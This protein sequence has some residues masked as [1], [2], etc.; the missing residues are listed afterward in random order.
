MSI[1]THIGPVRTGLRD[2]VHDMVIRRR[3]IRA[4]HETADAEPNTAPIVTIIRQTMRGRVDSHEQIVIDR[5]ETV[6]RKCCGLPP[7]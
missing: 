6:R 1:A 2:A 3:M 4:V 7:K 5:I